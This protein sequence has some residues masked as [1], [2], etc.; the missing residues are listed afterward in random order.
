MGGVR[1]GYQWREDTTCESDLMKAFNDDLFAVTY[2]YYCGLV[3]QNGELASDSAWFLESPSETGCKPSVIQ[4][5]RKTCY[6]AEVSRTCLVLVK[7]HANQ[8]Y[9]S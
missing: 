4:T 3:V 8:G 6:Y 5:H 1:H 2:S 9:C 7:K